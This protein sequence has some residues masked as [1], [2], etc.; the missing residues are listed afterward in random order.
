[1]LFGGVVGAEEPPHQG[2]IELGSLILHPKLVSAH[3]LP[4]VVYSLFW[5]TLCSTLAGKGLF[6]LYPE[7]ERPRDTGCPTGVHEHCGIATMSFSST[8]CGQQQV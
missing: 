7:N 1:M 4:N 8:L 2:K 5:G 3:I 6:A